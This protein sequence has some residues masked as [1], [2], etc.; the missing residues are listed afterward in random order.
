[1]NRIQQ[2][3]SK[4]Q[5][6]ILS[7]YFTAGFPQL[8][9]TVSIIELLEKHGV[10]M[11][12][13]GIPFSDPL[14]DGNVIQHSST[15]A[16]A[17]GMSLS[18]LFSQLE[19]IRKTVSIPLILMGYIN[20]VLQFGVE[21]FCETCQ[22]IGIDG[23]ILPDLP[24]HEYTKEYKHIFEQYG[25]QNILLIS[26]QTEE[27]RIRMIDQQTQAFIYM[28]SSSSTTGTKSKF[29]DEQI[30]YFKRI[31]SMNLQNPLLVGFG[32]SNTETF[33]QVCEYTH[34]AIVGSACIKALEQPGTL[35]QN[36]STFVS[37]IKG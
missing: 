27:S 1:M 9:D 35:E 5:K 12:E 16:L 18:V 15:V 37:S 2:L 19:H 32:I 13:I 33:A 34:G 8:H 29:N 21:K 20:P 36:I 4:K 25:I 14:A 17:N 30:H 26:P 6:Q 23:V 3:F 11:I 24:L 10:D 22:S 31:S 7:V 28:V